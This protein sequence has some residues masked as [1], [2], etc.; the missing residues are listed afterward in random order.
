LRSAQV[1]PDML[2]W[3]SRPS[4]GVYPVLVIQGIVVKVRESQVSNLPV[5]VAIGV[6]LDGERDAPGAKGAP[7]SG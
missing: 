4:D 2:A 6:N 5:F 1:L 7:S 3:Q